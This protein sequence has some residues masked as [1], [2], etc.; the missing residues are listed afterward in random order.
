MTAA[1][2][3]PQTLSVLDR[4][5]ELAATRGDAEAM[6]T[7]DGERYTWNEWYEASRKFA[8]ALIGAGVQRG[9]RIAV[10][11]AN[12]PLWPIADLGALLAGVVSVGIY[13]TN[14]SSQVIEMLADCGAKVIVVDS[15]EQVAKVLVG[16]DT[17]PMLTHIISLAGA[18]P[19]VSSWSDWLVSGERALTNGSAIAALEAAA[20]ESQGSDIA[21]MIYTSGSTGRPKGAQISL[22]C[23]RASAASTQATLGLTDRDSSLSFLPFSHAGERIFGLYTRIV[24]GMPVM[25]V[26]DITDVW[27]A[28]STYEPT[29]F[30]GLPRFYEK[31]SEALRIAEQNGA[32]S[33][34]RRAIVKQHFG[35]RL[36]I[37]TSG[38]AALP[39][40]VARHLEN[41]GVVVLG[42]YGQTEHLCVAFHRPDG[43]DFESVGVPMP[44]T[45]LRIAGDG[46]VLVR[47]SALTFSGYHGLPNASREAFTDDGEWLYTGDLGAITD[48]GTLVISGRKKELIALSTGKKIAPLPIE[49]ALTDGIWISHAMLYGEGHKFISALLWLGRPAAEAWAAENGSDSSLDLLAQQSGIRTAVDAMVQKVNANLSRSEQIKEWVLLGSEPTVEGGDLTPTLKLRRTDVVARYGH[50]LEHFYHVTAA[51]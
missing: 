7:P 13:P 15:V 25:I 45:E 49:A 1:L 18:V 2:P 46:E 8:A 42:A 27:K 41:N 35:S 28:A 48:R 39:V 34:T 31:V 14:A 19:G 32:N 44:G 29:L 16:R 5:R 47:R 50:L 9:D 11:A 22:D 36:R 12:R 24:V 21:V 30:G 6:R 51:R 33:D 17:L 26:S 10:L 37:A 23:L 3:I 43:Y 38:G 20:R 4:F 40:D